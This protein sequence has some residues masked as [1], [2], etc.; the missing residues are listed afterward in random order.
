MSKPSTPPSENNIDLTNDHVTNSQTNDT[1]NHVT[2]SVSQPIGNIKRRRP[3]EYIED[4]ILDVEQK[5]IV[6]KKTLEAELIEAREELKAKR[7]KKKL[8]Q[9]TTED[10]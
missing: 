8:K 5:I 9:Y 7:L 10:E 3:I 6:L 4:D 1:N 2:N